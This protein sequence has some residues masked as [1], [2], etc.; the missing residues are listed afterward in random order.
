[1]KVRIEIDGILYE[2][3][4]EPV[5]NVLAN[6]N[7]YDLTPETLA[8]SAPIYE[9]V[10]RPTA[11]TSPAPHEVTETT[12]KADSPE[13]ALPAA[14]ERTTKAVRA[15]K[16]GDKVYEI[17]LVDKTKKW[18][19]NPKE[20]EDAGYNFGMVENITDAE[21]SEYKLVL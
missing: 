4:L 19:R 17:N 15:P 13:D 14:P 16:T 18:I 21:M 9:E 1:M 3:Q 10:G 20:L 2:G 8:L 6:N 7:P 12:E 5:A 11:D